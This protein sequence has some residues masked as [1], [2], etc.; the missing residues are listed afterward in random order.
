MKISE[1]W[2]EAYVA[3]IKAGVPQSAFSSIADDA[4]TQYKTRQAALIDDDKAEA[5][6]QQAARTPAKDDKK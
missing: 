1:L 3:A 5:A 4:V 2:K 6:A